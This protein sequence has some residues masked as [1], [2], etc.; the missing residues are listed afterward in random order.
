MDKEGTSVRQGSRERLVKNLNLKR[1]LINRDII[2]LALASKIGTARNGVGRNRGW[3]SG[4]M[5]LV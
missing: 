4:G 5:S 1:I 2:F 3:F